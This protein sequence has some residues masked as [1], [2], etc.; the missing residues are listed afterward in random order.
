MPAAWVP[1]TALP[2]PRR[3][4]RS[5]SPRLGFLICVASVVNVA[6]WPKILKALIVAGLPW[7]VVQWL[8]LRDCNAGAQVQSPVRER[9]PTC[10]NKDPAQPNN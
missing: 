2:P 8:R 5:R 6:D 4:T 9:D 3:V 10:R 7:L 1:V